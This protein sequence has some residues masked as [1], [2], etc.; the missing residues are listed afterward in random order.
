VGAP[1]GGVAQPV[2]PQAAPGLDQM[3]MLASML[4][5][6]QS[7]QLEAQRLAT[8]RESKQ[9]AAAAE[10]AAILR[11]ELA[12]QQATQAEA[13]AKQA[14]ALAKQQAAIA[15]AAAKQ[16]EAMAKLNEAA[17]AR[18]ERVA[19]REIQMLAKLKRALVVETREVVDGARQTE[20]AAMIDALRAQSD[21][22][23][24]AEHARMNS[25]PERISRR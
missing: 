1:G 23:R 24:A 16:A 9:L 21:N 4:Q 11:V 12:K 5:L 13:A 20:Q 22:A 10:S 3:T 25:R 17:A 8:E 19:E 6:M 7:S 18:D 15:E 14:E 2:V